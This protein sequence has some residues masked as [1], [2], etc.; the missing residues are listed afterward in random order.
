ELDVVLP[1][2]V[3]ADVSDAERAILHLNAESSRFARLEALAR[4]LLRAESVASS[5]IEG[6]QVGPRRLVRA[7]AARAIGIAM[8]D[9]TAEAVLGNVEAMALAVSEVV[10]R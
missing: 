9:A 6:L 4:L 7:E 5:R 2:E 8:E 1:A 10:S 3:A